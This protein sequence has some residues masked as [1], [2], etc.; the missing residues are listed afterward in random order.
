MSTVSKQVFTD[1]SGRRWKTLTRSGAVFALVAAALTVAFVASLLAVPFL[2][3]VGSSVRHHSPGLHLLP[4]RKAQLMRLLLHRERLKLQHTMAQEQARRKAATHPH[5]AGNQIVA[6]FYGSWQPTGLHSLRANASKLTHLL[7][8]WLRLDAS[9][10]KLSTEAWE[11]TSAPAN[12]SAVRIAREHGVAI[13]PVLSN[14]VPG[15]FD[16]RRVERLLHSAHSQHTLALQLRDWLREQG[17]QGLNVDFESLTTRDYRRLPT[18]LRL[19]HRVLGQAGLQLSID[20]EAAEER[21]DLRRVATTTDFVVLMAYDEHYAEGEAGPIASAGWFN[22]VLRAA[23]HQIPAQKLVVGL[24][25]YAYDWPAAGGRAEAI[26]FLDALMLA[27]EAREEL[28]PPERVDFDT[29]ALNPTFNY[30][31]ED[32]KQHEV[33][34]LDAVTVYN[35]LVMAT[36]LNVRGT[37]LWVLG[38]EDPEIWRLLRRSRPLGELPRPSELSD[39]KNAANITYVG[40][41]EVLTVAATP[42]RG[43]RTIEVDPHTGLCTD[44]TWETFPTPYVIQRSGYT[45]GAI[46]LTF[47]DGP[48][49]QYT[50]ELL[51][52]L[53]AA[54][55]HATFF[56]IGDNAER[57]PEIVR[58]IWREGHEIGNHTFSHPNLAAVSGQRATLELNASQRALQSIL[59]RST[60]LFRAPYNADAEPTSAEEVTPIR[61]ASELGYLTIGELI[62]PQDWNL[63]RAQAAGGRTRRTTASIVDDVMR[64]V[65]TT[66]GNVVLLHDGGGNRAHTVAAVRQLIPRLRA[67]GKHFV[68]VSQLMGKT[69]NDVM[70]ALRPQDQLLV[71]VDRVVFDTVFAIEAALSVAFLLAIGLGLLR[72]LMIVPLAILHRRRATRRQY[73]P[74]FRP[75]VSVLVAAYNEQPVIVRTLRAILRNAYPELEVIVIDDGS[76]DGTT[77]EVQQSFADEPRVRVIRQSNAGKAGAMNRGIREASGDVL[78]CLD[79]DTQIGP[80]TIAQLVKHFADPRI[81][82]VAGNV[83]V[84]NARGMLTRWQSIEYLTSQNLDREAYALINAVTVVPGAVG[85]WRRSAVLSVGGVEPDTLAEDRDLTW[86]LRQANWVIETEAAAEGWTEAPER[87]RDLFKQ[88]FRWTHGTL[89]CMWKHRRAAFRHGSFGWVAVPTL[90]LF[91]VVFQALAPLIDLQLLFVGVTLLQAWLVRGVYHGDWQPLAQAADQARLV[92]FFYGLFFLVELISAAIA[93]RLDRSRPWVLW[94]LFWQRF[95]YRQLMYAVLWKSLVSALRGLRQG[96]G[97]LD[98]RGTVNAP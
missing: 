64:D 2:P 65:D 92:G 96:W 42:K 9:G 89:Q 59:G 16:A 97:K 30:A 56:L 32:N 77:E 91:E 17:F 26:D 81:A 41:G 19:L 33:W 55:V 50:P 39:L 93:F 71:G 18:F 13:H 62:D 43:L 75:R 21:L 10:A 69:R 66:K 14:A 82:A 51:D 3:S 31:D 38:G 1:P 48:S 23:L 29:D 68:T 95:V 15:G 6:A 52:V 37:A 5:A 45:P 25:N 72:V 67:Q 54:G 76:T 53:K 46:A 83:R 87:L 60:L 74:T 47:D 85:A 8:T 73:D 24:G 94:R 78:V 11:G 28:P 35:Q 7:P 84:G 57:Y 20:V 86:R 27:R 58:R 61:V 12:R 36:S 70:P 44:E 79:A 49:P 90:W 63:Y 22:N 34:M 98:R 4:S 40:E 80:E 88:R